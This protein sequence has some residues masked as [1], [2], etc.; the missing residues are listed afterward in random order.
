[1]YHGM[2]NV[3]SLIRHSNRHRTMVRMI[4]AHTLCILLLL[5]LLL[6]L[7]NVRHSESWL[8]DSGNNNAQNDS[9]FDFNLVSFSR[10]PDNFPNFSTHTMWAAGNVGLSTALPLCRLLITH[11]L[12]RHQL[13]L[14]PPQMHNLAINLEQL[15]HCS[16]SFQL[17]HHPISVCC[18][19]LA[20]THAKILVC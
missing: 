9:L 13:K 4:L 16:C 1:M 10:D 6:V 2:N 17:V 5:S 12:L 7:V 8:L 20:R 18:K 14:P 19:R 11:R 15:H 3:I